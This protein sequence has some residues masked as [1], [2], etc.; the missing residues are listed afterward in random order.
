MKCPFGYKYNT[1]AVAISL[2]RI[3]RSRVGVLAVDLLEQFA[4]DFIEVVFT[5]TVC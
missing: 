2:E 4:S 5:G 1:T 3:L